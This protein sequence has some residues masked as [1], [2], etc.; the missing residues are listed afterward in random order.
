M[1]SLLRGRPEG[2]G[3]DADPLEEV[4]YAPAA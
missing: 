2:L 1:A 3:G 4:K